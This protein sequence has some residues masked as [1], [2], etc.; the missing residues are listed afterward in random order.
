[1]VTPRLMPEQIAW[2]SDGVAQ[3]ITAQRLRYAPRAGSLS[4][5]QLASMNGFFSAAVLKTSVVTLQNE[6]VQNP[7][8]Y[9]ALVALGFH[10]LPD[11]STMAAI[12]FND[13]VVSH[14]A[15]TNGLLFHELVHVEQYRQLGIARFSERYVNGFLSGGGYDN[16]PLETHAYSLG[17]R[18]KANTQQRFSVEEAVSDSIRRGAY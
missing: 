10:N 11:Q 6:R 17:A 3:Y 4:A 7:E 2:L 8:F 12:T 9:P 18:Y 15:F 16:I 14:V 1:M 5:Q 13:V